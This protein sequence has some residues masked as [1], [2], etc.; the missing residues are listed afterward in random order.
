MTTEQP[1]SPMSPSVLVI[2]D[3][4]DLCSMI[5]DTL[6]VRDVNCDLA[7]STDEAI[8]KLRDHHYSAIL[9]SPRLPVTTDP[10]MHFLHEQQPGEVR[11]VILMADPDSTL[12]KNADRCPVLLKPFSRDQLF[13]KVIR[14]LQP[15]PC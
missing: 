4:A 12:E 5:A 7:R 8:A 3:Y 2:E 1:R 15:Q 10:V 13:D 9:L 11:K 6:H 14:A